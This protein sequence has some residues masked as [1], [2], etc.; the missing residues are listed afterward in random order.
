VVPFA[1]E[2]LT[3]YEV[4]AKT[5]LLDRRLRVN[6]S[7]FYNKYKNIQVVLLSCPQFSGGN[8]NE[9]CA[10]PTNGGDANIY[11]VELETS[12]R[13]EGLTIDGSA[14]KQHFEYTSI[15]PASGISLSAPGQ[16][17][18]PLKWSIGAQYEFPFANGSNVTPRL[19]YIYSSGFFTNASGDSHSYIAGY[20]E[21]NGR[22]TWRSPSTKWEAAV[23]GTN[24]T[25]KLW[26]NSVFDLYATQGQVYGLPSAPRTVEIQFKRNF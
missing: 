9:P 26:Y 2:S 22:I 8:A 10:A 19:D 18:Q 13:F 17:F 7:S 11:G 15:D 23:L 21:L 4:G 16:N 24:L 12:Y 25:N 20:H 6:V 1:T 3:A 5:D 14:S